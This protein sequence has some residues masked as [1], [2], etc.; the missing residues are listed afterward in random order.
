[1]TVKQFF[2]FNLWLEK[3]DEIE[4]AEKCKQMVGTYHFKDLLIKLMREWLEKQ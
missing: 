4:T 3:E 1:M 2:R